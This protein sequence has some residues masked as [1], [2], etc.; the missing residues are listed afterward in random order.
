[1]ALVSGVSK[2]MTEC[3][4]RQS[5]RHQLRCPDTRLRGRSRFGVAKARHLKPILLKEKIGKLNLY[6]KNYSQDTSGAV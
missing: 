5:A 3:E 2:Q 4:I 6:L 1:M